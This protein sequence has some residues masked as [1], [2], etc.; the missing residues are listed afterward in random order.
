[1]IFA[2]VLLLILAQAI[3]SVSQ[4]RQENP[5]TSIE[6]SDISNLRIVKTDVRLTENQNYRKLN[7][8]RHSA[9]V[10]LTVQN[11]GQQPVTRIDAD[12]VF[13][14]IDDLKNMEEQLRPVDRLRPFKYN[15]SQQNL[16]HRPFA[17][18]PDDTIDLILE[19]ECLDS[20]FLKEAAHIKFI[21]YAD[22][23]TW[24]RQR[25]G[26]I[27]VFFD[28]PDCEPEKLAEPNYPP[29]AHAAL[30]I[31]RVIVNVEVDEKGDVISATVISGHP[32]LKD[33]ALVAARNCKFRMKNT[34]GKSVTGT[35][36]FSFQI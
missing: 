10:V 26:E 30:V 36:T 18:N 6:E 17:L 25:R 27:K 31:G 11:S 14:Y 20:S 24:E 2:T 21:Q 34:Q 9:T 32:L 22:G 15:I 8:C 16:A 4:V 5:I 1:M 19:I 29:L 12:I 35:I 7:K 28:I 13:Y 33:A 3:P 23:S